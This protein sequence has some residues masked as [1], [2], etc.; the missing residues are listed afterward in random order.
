MQLDII[1]EEYDCCNLVQH[2]M[3]PSTYRLK[4]NYAQDYSNVWFISALFQL[5]NTILME[6]APSL[7]T[8]D[9]WWCWCSAS[10]PLEILPIVHT[11]HSLPRCGKCSRQLATLRQFVKREVQQSQHS[12]TG[13]ATDGILQIL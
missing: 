13:F 4:C 12:P 2:G 5:M 9:P 11:G 3:L 7:Q 6:Y 8:F 1:I 10:L